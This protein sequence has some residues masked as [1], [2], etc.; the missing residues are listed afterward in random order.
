MT[1]DSI[2]P[3]IPQL[4]DARLIAFAGRATS[5]Q[6]RL[7][8]ATGTDQAAVR[9]AASAWTVVRLEVEASEQAMSGFR[10][11]SE[12]TGLNRRAGNA[13]GSLPSRRLLAAM[14]AC[15]RAYRLTDGRFDPRV[16]TALERLGDRG[17]SIGR[18]DGSVAPRPGTRRPDRGARGRWPDSSVRT[19]RP[20]GD[21]GGPRLSVGGV[22]SEAGRVRGVPD[23]CRR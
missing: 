19:D 20:R 22:G 21:R 15:D 13:R 16:L 12:I 11:T 10:E 14:T 3:T 18:A 5:S 6:L 8:I 23:R 7:T 4:A 1:V 9:R 2:A 17:T